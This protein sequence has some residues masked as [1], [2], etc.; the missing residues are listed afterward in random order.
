MGL[1][2]TIKAKIVN[3]VAR[4]KKFLERKIHFVVLNSS[5]TNDGFYQ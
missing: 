4:Q 5:D 3:M 1:A 2:K